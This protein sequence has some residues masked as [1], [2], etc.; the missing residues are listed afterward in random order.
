[1]DDCIRDPNLWSSSEFEFLLEEDGDNP[2]VI[3]SRPIFQYLKTVALESQGINH[4]C[5]D[6]VICD[7][8]PGGQVQSMQVRDLLVDRHVLEHKNGRIKINVDLF[9]RYVVYRYGN[10]SQGGI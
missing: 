4:D 8:L 5:S 1:M 10:S 3:E 2:G 7:A 6:K 9:R